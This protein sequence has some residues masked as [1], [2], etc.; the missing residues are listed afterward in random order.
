MVSFS[1]E[2]EIVSNYQT[3]TYEQGCHVELGKLYDNVS[4]DTSDSTGW[5]TFFAL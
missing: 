2:I 4:L 3:S 5:T 1:A